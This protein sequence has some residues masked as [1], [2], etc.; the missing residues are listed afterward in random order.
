M[1]EAAQAG[2]SLEFAVQAGCHLL[3]IPSFETFVL[4]WHLFCCRD[5]VYDAVPRRVFGQH[6]FNPPILRC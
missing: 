6:L 3:I 2:N 5:L 4:G 1:S